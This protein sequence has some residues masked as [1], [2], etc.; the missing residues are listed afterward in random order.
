MVSP[1]AP[2]LNMALCCALT[3]GRACSYSETNS[4]SVTGKLAS[5]DSPERL[6]SGLV[7][8]SGHKKREAE[9]IDKARASV[10]RRRYILDRLKDVRPHRHRNLPALNGIAR[11][12]TRAQRPTLQTGK[13][14]QRRTTEQTGNRAVTCMF[15]CRSLPSLIVDAFRSSADRPPRCRGF[16]RNTGLP[17][18]RELNASVLKRFS[19]ATVG[20]SA[21]NG[22]PCPTERRHTCDPAPYQ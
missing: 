10:L 7:L 11:G 14:E 17:S 20:R 18:I 3:S 8:K 4:P 13:L 6:A 22:R 9:R 2:G 5:S 1:S 12:R 19:F 16:R 21:T 15:L